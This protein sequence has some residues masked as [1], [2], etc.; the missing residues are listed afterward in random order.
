MGLRPFVIFGISV[1]AIFFGG[2]ICWSAWA[3]LDSAAVAPGVVSLDTN[4]KT[5][6]HLEGG[7]VSEIL[8]GEG[9]KVEAG[10]VLLRLDP[11]QA[12]ANLERLRAALEALSASAARL[13]A[14][15]DGLDVVT[16]PDWME[17]RRDD[18]RIAQQLVTQ[19]NL[20]EAGQ[21]RYDGYVSIYQQQISQQQEEI[22]GLEGQIAAEE[23][24]LRLI[25]EELADTRK[26]F[27]KRLIP[28]P[29]LLALERHEAELKGNR[30]HHLAAIARA[31]QSIGEKKVRIAELDTARVNEA[32]QKLQ[33]VQSQIL[34]LDEKIRT[35]EDIL[36]RT[37]I[38]SPVSGSVLGLKVH[39]AGGVI[40]PGE[41]LMDIVPRDER[42]L[43]E[44]E[45]DPSD[46]E[47]VVPG[48][49]TQ[50]RLTAFQQR[51][52]APLEGR[53]VSVSADRMID[54]REGRAFYLGRVELLVDPSTVLDGGMIQPGMQAAVIILTGRG[55]VL[56][57][58]L[59]PVSQIF[60][61]AFRE[62]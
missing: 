28:K 1:V 55:T 31:E 43:I 56:D 58:L 32:V 15:R 7:I 9:D 22:K 14:E 13:A 59:R 34:E 38:R 50:V 21:R 2:L 49:A 62:Q 11:L 51:N 52:L 24:Q 40:G 4:R 5:I 19:T 26:L 25:R 20:F 41:P 60:E 39:T 16:F 3:P 53:L 23:E 8:V 17:R 37:E 29:R 44:V 54:E 47:T 30:S 46:I 35:A 45:I 48:Q 42:L 57:Y 10:Q 27:E 61:R 36:K 6:Q 18:V 12:T 33:D